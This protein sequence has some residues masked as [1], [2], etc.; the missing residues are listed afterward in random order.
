VT[1][2][3]GSDRV[4][5]VAPFLELW[6][7]AGDGEWRHLTA[8]DLP[9]A[10]IRWRATVGNIK[11]FR[12]T[13]DANDKVEATTGWFSDHDRMALLGRAGNFLAGKSIPLGD[14]RFIRPTGAFPQLRVRYTPAHGYVYG[15]DAF[16]RK[17]N[18]EYD[19]ASGY[20]QA[21]SNIRD[22]VYDSA[23]GGWLGYVESMP[24]NQPFT[25]TFTIPPQI[26]AGQT[27]EH[28]YEWVSRGYLDDE[29]DGILEVEVESAGGV[30]RSFARFGAGPP[31][32]APDSYPIRSVYDELEQALLGP[33]IDPDEYSDDELQ[34]EAEEILRR[35]FEAVR[36]M[37]TTIMNGNAF[38]GQIDIASTMVRQ[39]RGDAARAWETIMA[40]TIVDNLA[41]QSLHENIFTVLRS[42]AP[43]WF[44]SA[45]RRF[46]EIGDLT[47]LGRRKM[48][49]MM[50]N[51]DGRYLCL[52]RRQLDK[53][54]VAASRLVSRSAAGSGKESR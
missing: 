14:V 22:V 43:P 26:F 12:R 32:Y 31:A 5:P 7:H 10:A 4:R 48:P 1:F 23:K 13:G 54:R 27:G 6:G 46:D 34:A 37:N 21:D 15:S 41:V 19:M 29:C 9:G 52:T 36:L 25:P 20:L 2:K 45:L 40:P 33:T 49:G 24:P 50:R 47:D 17:A 16:V 42:G 28:D 39:D 18:G 44:V 38:Q 8:A 51:A 35:A 3:D 53:I 11:V 30:L